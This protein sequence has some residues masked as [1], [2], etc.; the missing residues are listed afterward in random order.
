MISGHI[1]SQNM[2]RYLLLYY[3]HMWT[4]VIEVILVNINIS[5]KIVFRNVILYN[6]HVRKWDPVDSILGFCMQRP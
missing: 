6:M 1:N 3:Y 4:A 5:T 2:K